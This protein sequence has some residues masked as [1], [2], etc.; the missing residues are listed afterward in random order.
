MQ[1]MRP[2]PVNTSIW[3]MLSKFRKLEQRLC[4]AGFPGFLARLPYCLLAWQY[5]YSMEGKMLRIQRISQRMRAWLAAMKDLCARNDA[6]TELFDVSLEMYDDIEV[7]K[8][9]LMELRDI[10]LDV[11]RL[12]DFVGYT[13]RRLMRLQDSFVKLL[14]ECYE[15]ASTLQCLVADHDRKALA[16]L[17]AT[18][19]GSAQA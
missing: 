19:S 10:C 3:E 8:R 1:A 14:A 13:S 17:R 12:F 16:L 2:H 15:A 18:H 11:T 5:C 4:A 9:T 6:Q 7:T